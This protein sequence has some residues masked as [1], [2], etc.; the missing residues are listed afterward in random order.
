[1]N[2]PSAT[3][4]TRRRCSGAALPPTSKLDL[5]VKRT[6]TVASDREDLVHIDWSGE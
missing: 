4:W 5:L 3:R 6:D 2:R 1:M